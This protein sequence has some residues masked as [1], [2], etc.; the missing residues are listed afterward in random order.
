VAPAAGGHGRFA[1]CETLR[2]VRNTS[3]VRVGVVGHVEWV[4]FV[5]VPALPARGEIVHADAAW[6]EPAGGGAVAAVQLLRLAGQATLFTALGADERGRCS[7]ERLRALG[8]TVHAAKRDEPQRRA[9]TFV[10]ALGERTITV[11]GERM[12]PRRSDPLPWPELSEY[13]AVYFT[14]GDVGALEAARQASVLVATPRALEV[15]RNAAVQLDALVGSGR[16]PGEVYADGDIDPP[17]KLVVETHGAA[18][19]RWRAVDG[20]A[21]TY[22]PAS[23][24][25]PGGDAYGAGDCFAAGLTFGLGVGLPLADALALADRCGAA[26]RGVSGAYGGLT[27][28]A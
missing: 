11:I 13:D 16:D 24:L 17:P 18:G 8:L 1:R 2:P 9:V 22:A 6:E 7:G 5:S 10:D 4:E 28:S 12:V 25:P 27:A 20:R 21:G 15:L 3:P 19:G 26:A 23:S 14:G